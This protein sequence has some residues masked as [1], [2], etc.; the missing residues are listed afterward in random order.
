MNI[1]KKFRRIL[2]KSIEYI[3]TKWINSEVEIFLKASLAGSQE[4]S[5]L[6]DPM[7]Y[8]TNLRKFIEPLDFNISSIKYDNQ[9]KNDTASLRFSNLIKRLQYHTPPIPFPIA[10]TI[11]KYADEYFGNLSS[12]EFG[13]Y[14][15]DVAEH[16]RKSSSTGHK[17]RFLATVVRFMRPK[18]CLEL[19]TCYGMSAVVIISMLRAMGDFESFDTIDGF[20]PMCS[21]SKETLT[22]QFGELVT[23]HK[24][25][26][27]KELP[28]ILKSKNHIDF[29]FHD[30]G[31][32]R[33]S[34]INDFNM[35]EPH[36]SSGAVIILDDLH[37][38][39][40]RFSVNPPQTYEG[41]KEII[42]HKRV[43]SA[44]EINKK[45]GLILID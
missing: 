43:K 35:M 19:G 31:H 30:A 37:W 45:M 44:I 9:Q 3:Q 4:L 24:G 18:T 28:K 25:L 41:W 27:Q 14:A 5:D 22:N 6:N 8:I 11:A 1:K 33:E 20:E 29:V 13:E 2:D 38:N 7:A 32:S 17:A 26:I 23:C 36:L 10:K 34:Y 12:F 39:N 42:K 21:L 40:P 16:F 15:A